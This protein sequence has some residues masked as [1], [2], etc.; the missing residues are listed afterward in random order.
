MVEDRTATSIE[1]DV[2]S[3]K[4]EA[5]S[6]LRGIEAAK[7]PDSHFIYIPEI[8]SSNRACEIPFMMDSGALFE[9]RRKYHILESV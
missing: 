4:L 9:L 6:I 7:V 1:A 3:L 8:S 2:P 5:S